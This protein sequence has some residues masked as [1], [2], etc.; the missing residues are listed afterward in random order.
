MSLHLELIEVIED[1][2]FEGFEQ[3][4]EMSAVVDI[5]HENNNDALITAIV[6]GE[7]DM[8]AELLSLDKVQASAH[9]NGNEVLLEAIKQNDPIIV[10]FLLE[11]PEVKK[12]A[13]SDPDI[14]IQVIEQKDDTLLEVFLRMSEFQD[15][16]HQNDNELLDHALTINNLKAANRLCQIQQVKNGLYDYLA[17]LNLDKEMGSI[18]KLFALPAIQDSFADIMN[19]I[20]TRLVE[21]GKSTDLLFTKLIELS[22]NRL[23]EAI[24]SQDQA[25]IHSLLSLSIS[26]HMM[27][28]NNNAILHELLERESISIAN[29]VV[30][31]QKV[32]DK[33]YDYVASLV[34]EDNET[35]LLRLFSLEHFQKITDDLLE[36]LL[37]QAMKNDELDI[38]AS[39][40]QLE[41]V[42]AVLNKKPTIL[43]KALIEEKYEY[44]K[45]LLILPG[46]QQHGSMLNNAALMQACRYGTT[47]EIQNI[48]KMP[49]VKDNTKISESGTTPIHI[50]AVQNNIDLLEIF[51]NAGYDI[52]EADYSGN[53]PLHVAAMFN[54][55]NVLNKL[56]ELGADKK[57][58]NNKGL[59]ALSIAIKN[60]SR[61]AQGI[62]VAAGLDESASRAVL[63]ADSQIHQAKILENLAKWLFLTEDVDQHSTI[64]D[65]IFDLISKGGYC[66]G[67]SWL[68]KFLSHNE[69][70]R[71]MHR[72]TAWSGDKE[73]LDADL[74]QI[75]SIVIP[76]IVFAQ[77]NP[78][79]S[80]R[81]GL[82]DKDNKLI[83]HQA[84]QQIGQ[85]IS[86]SATPLIKTHLDNDYLERDFR[87]FEQFV[88][89]YGS[90]TAKFGIAGLVEVGSNLFLGKEMGAHAIDF[91]T[92]YENGKQYYWYM[93]PNAPEGKQVFSDLK[94]C[95]DALVT[96][97][98]CYPEGTQTLKMEMGVYEEAA[99]SFQKEREFNSGAIAEIGLKKRLARSLDSNHKVECI[100]KAG[101]F[102]YI[103]EQYGKFKLEDSTSERTRFF[104]TIDDLIQILEQN[105][106][107]IE[108]HVEEMIVY[109]AELPKYITAEK[110]DHSFMS[111]IEMENFDV[112]DYFIENALVSETTLMKTLA[113]AVKSNNDYLLERIL[114][115]KN[116]DVNKPLKDENGNEISLLSLA[117]E[118]NN[119]KAIKILMASGADPATQYT[120]PFLLGLTLDNVECVKQLFTCASAKQKKQ[121]LS[122]K[123]EDNQSLV[124][125]CKSSNMK[126]LVMTQQNR[127]KPQTKKPIAISFTATRSKSEPLIR[128][129]HSNLRSKKHQ[130]KKRKAKK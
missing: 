2:D 14:L 50:A 44:S 40:I 106:P 49:K 93:D 33:L 82:N 47:E 91:G 58:E 110:L 126:D 92:S 89:K 67:F 56:L 9:L 7:T 118:K 109:K 34:I 100:T 85:L 42:Q 102:I 78:D 123:P 32:L 104:D 129:S 74:N 105:H 51:I 84:A 130:N 77:Q 115:H 54:N 12:L 55:T 48:L 117:M 113:D 95:F 25:Q 97:V 4:L 99:F 1:G 90:N 19:N 31:N 45:R 68:H 13:L 39:L 87:A 38:F 23:I 72:I 88:L 28:I 37:M 124:E 27:A 5:A 76:I 128:P 59:N 57:A 29:Q 80:E 75:M 43:K 60:K 24:R 119:P 73:D 121:M 111:N 22:Y 6:L 61:D 81:L 53:T 116:I 8:A 79:L 101:D 122:L 66:N 11:L 62:L 41:P 63:E 35:L 96:D 30:Q 127:Y 46:L 103:S 10:K 112:I 20:M 107:E 3:L 120:N 15:I 83:Y 64:K 86:S 108:Q 36:N 69:Y 71:V 16:T 114:S 18:D 70:D 94:T 65:T 52:H 98:F 125:I 26:E 21:R 17:Y